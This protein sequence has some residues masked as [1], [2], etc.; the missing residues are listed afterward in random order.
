MRVRRSVTERISAVNPPA[1]STVRPGFSFPPAEQPR[2]HDARPV[3]DEQIARG[4]QVR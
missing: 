2:P 4:E 3:D 1:I